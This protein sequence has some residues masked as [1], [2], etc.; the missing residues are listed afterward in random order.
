MAVMMAAAGDSGRWR[1][2]VVGGGGG[3]W[4]S[5]DGRGQLDSSSVHFRWQGG[6]QRRWQSGMSR[7]TEGGAMRLSWR[8]PR[9]PSPTRIN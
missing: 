3:G 4:W 9:L 7:S 8:N 6:R 1:T 2:M 5:S